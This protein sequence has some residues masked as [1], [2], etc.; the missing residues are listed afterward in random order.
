MSEYQVK[1]NEATYMVQ[2]PKGFLG[3]FGTNFWRSWVCP[4]YTP[5]GHNVVQEFPFDHP[6]H[7]GV[8]VGQ[9]PVFCGEREANFWA[10]PVKRKHGDALMEKQGRMDPQGKPEL[11]ISPGSV[12]FK[13]DSI[14][15]DQN[16]EPILN[17]R[18]TVVFSSVPGATIC[19]MSSEKTAAYGPVTFA[20]TKFGSIGVRVEPRL[21]PKLGGRVIGV[22]DGELA[23]GSADEVASGKDVDAVAYEADIPG[24][25]TL[26]VCLNISMNSASDSNRGPWFIRDYGMAMFNATQNAPITLAEGESWEASLRVLAYDGS[27]QTTWFGK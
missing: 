12:R 13:L 22:R 19:T 8:F 26:G 16:E 23:Y 20:K 9:N 2:G 1:V 7:N 11:I 21:L 15:R 14:W 24:V 5:S 27:L 6:F 3:A 18:R 4:L 10:F 25:G 17:E